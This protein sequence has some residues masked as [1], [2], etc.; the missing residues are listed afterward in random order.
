MK[1]ALLRVLFAVATLPALAQPDPIEIFDEVENFMVD[2]SEVYVR[3]QE[4]LL[5][6]TRVDLTQHGWRRLLPTVQLTFNARSQHYV[7]VPVSTAGSLVDPALRQWPADTWTLTAS[8]RLNAFIDPVPRRRARATV[9]AAEWNLAIAR[10]QRQQALLRAREALR[11][12]HRQ[13][14]ALTLMLRHLDERRALL[15]AGLAL[16]RDLVQLSQIKY[17]QGELT[18]EGLSAQRLSLLA[19]EGDLLAIEHERQRTQQELA[20]FRD[21]PEDLSHSIPAAPPTQRTT[22]H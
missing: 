17:E 8:W 9:R 7:F 2:T 3:R 10:H 21:G 5:A 14:A 19:L 6:G 4:A 18:Y 15:E 11:E 12:R 16:R 13:K 1:I 22:D 20:T